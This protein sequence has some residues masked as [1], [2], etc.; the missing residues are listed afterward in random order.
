MTAAGTAKSGTVY[1][2]STSCG[3]TDGCFSAV[4]PLTTPANTLGTFFT[5]P[6]TPNSM[7]FDRKGTNAY[8]GTNSGLLGSV[9]LA[10]LD[11]AGSTLSSFKSSPGKV[12]AVSPDGTKIIISDTATADGPNRVFIFDATSKTPVTFQITGAT[13]AD[14]SPDSLKAFIAA[15]NN[16]Y[17]YSKLDALHTVPL[18]AP[19]GDVSFLSE[20]AFAYVAGGASSSVTVYR[21]CDNSLADTITLPAVPSFIKTLPDA[22][23]VLA[24]T[25]PTLDVINVSLSFPSTPPGCTAS[26]TDGFSSFNLGAFVAKQLI[27]STDGSTVYIVPSNLGQ[28]LVFNLSGQTFTGITLAGNATPLTASLTPD[29]SLLYV[30]ASD[31][32]LHI[33]DTRLGSDIHQVSFAPASLCQDSVGK[34]FPIACYPDLVAVR[35]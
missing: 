33:V 22:T 11:A 27:V 29:G 3:T 12:L 21:T 30:G 14:F 26:V 4:V 6:A 16:L 2:S 1:V 18:T 13:A 23:K 19:A 17:V 24:L 25:P 7:L 34:P 9:G 20:G 28:I 32:T 10:V 15:G 31:Q 5:L 8:I 35:P